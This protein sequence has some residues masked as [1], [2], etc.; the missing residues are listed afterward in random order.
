[1]GVCL[2]AADMY[3]S[4]YD[5]HQ[6]SVGLSH[7][8]RLAALTTGRWLLMQRYRK[9]SRG[10][11]RR[12]DRRIWVENW[13]HEPIVFMGCPSYQCDMTRQDGQDQAAQERQW[14]DT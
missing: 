6:E 2:T 13:V 14:V 12:H 4:M 9:G 1:M 10:R 8:G 5:R 7:L 3:L 11:L